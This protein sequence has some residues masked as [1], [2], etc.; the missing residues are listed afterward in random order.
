MTTEPALLQ[1]AQ[2]YDL[3]ALAEIYDRYSPGLYRYAMR[4]M[5]DEDLAEE[6]V[7]E[8]FNRFLSVLKAGRG[9][10]QYLQAYLYRVAHN[11]ITDY[12]RRQ[13]PPTL[14]LEPD[15]IHNPGSDPQVQVALELEK[16]RVRDALRLLTPEQRQVV[17]LKY[18][19]EWQNQEI[20]EAIEK[21]VGAVKALEHR[22]L[23]TLRRILMREEVRQQ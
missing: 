22:A 12:Y 9:P 1:R 13:P 10:Q 20:A 2:R 15:L 14:P 23:N 5:S 17:V 4:L 16:E 3:Q 11:W 7:A 8:T 21:Q 19:E 6:C 18:L